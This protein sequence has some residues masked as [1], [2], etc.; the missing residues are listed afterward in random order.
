[1]S[2]SDERAPE[3]SLVLACYNEAEHLPESVRQI[4]ATLRGMGIRYELIFIDDCS[5]DE[6]PRL[7]E[8]LCAGERDARFVL[9]AANVGRGGTV[10]EGFGLARG[11]IVGFLDVD[12]EVHCSFIPAVLAELGDDCEGAT[13][14]RVYDVGLAPGGI[15]RHVLSRGYRLLFRALFDVP[16]RD[17]ETGFKFFLRERILPVLDQARDRAWFWDTEIMVLAHLAGLRVS[18]VPVRFVRRNDKT[19]TVRVFR[20]TWRYLV[21]ALRIR[22]RLRAEPPRF[23]R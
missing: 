13:A 3:L 11:R 5:R 4:R 15:L 12:L 19:S 16:Y 1:L 17:T 18:E 20:D 2:S 8:Q 7:V 21:A 22:R 10:S 14:Y 6:T 9:H 23:G